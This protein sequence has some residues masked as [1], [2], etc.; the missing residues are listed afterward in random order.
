MV[1]PRGATLGPRS[2]DRFELVWVLSGS[3]TVAVEGERIHCEKSQILLLK[4]SLPNVFHFAKD[5][6]I[7]HAYLTFRFPEP[8]DVARA[9]V[10]PRLLQGEAVSLFLPVLN[11]LVE[12]LLMAG[13]TADRDANL[14]Q[15]VVATFLATWS[16]PILD[17]RR[18]A[19]VS[20]PALARA[21]ESIDVAWRCDQGAALSVRDVAN[22]ASITARQ[23]SRLF[24]AELGMSTR[25]YLRRRRLTYAARLLERS[26]LTLQV[27]AAEAGF[28]NEFAFSRA[29][30]AVY[31]T[32]PARYRRLQHGDDAGVDAS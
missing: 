10:L 29:F 15:R 9:H 8:A 21:L 11:Q 3:F 5:I 2:R 28:A 17:G 30:R 1:Y 16:W 23:L 6:A 27:I 18:S 32:P 25:D 13:P 20:S 4:P 14:A 19:A 12:H 26:N 22:A 31:G 7:R 24:R